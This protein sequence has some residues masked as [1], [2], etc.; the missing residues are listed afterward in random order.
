MMVSMGDMVSMDRMMSM[1]MI[2]SMNMVM[3]IDIVKSHTKLYAKPTCGET[4]LFKIDFRTVLIYI[5]L[6]KELYMLKFKH[7]IYFFIKYV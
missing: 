6:V 1:D 7:K 3:N 5:K 4:H 2:V